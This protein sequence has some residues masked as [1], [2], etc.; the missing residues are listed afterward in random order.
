MKTAPVVAW[1]VLNLA[2]LGAAAHLFGL[3]GGIVA[4]L[5]TDFLWFGITHVGPREPKP[6]KEASVD[7][8]QG[9]ASQVD[10]SKQHL[11]S[12]SMKM[13]TTIVWVLTGLSVS[14]FLFDFEPIWL[15]LIV[16]LVAGSLT[17]GW[18][19][20]ATTRRLPRS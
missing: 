5:V 12:K 4:V 3:V 16:G 10:A 18:F 1:L 17:S 2:L 14:Y 11:T 19:L 6:Q 9:K 8:E 13:L 7:H 15:R 20:W